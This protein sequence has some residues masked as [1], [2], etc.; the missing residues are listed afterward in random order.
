MIPTTLSLRTYDQLMKYLQE[1][2]LHDLDVLA[3]FSVVDSR[4]RLHQ[5]MI[6]ETSRQHPSVLKTTIPYASQIE[7]MGVFR[8]PVNTYASGTDSAKAYDALWQEV[9]AR[10]L[11]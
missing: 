3:F 1:N 6:E 2:K 5:D 10:V 11:R 4:R 9:K 7:R 8:A